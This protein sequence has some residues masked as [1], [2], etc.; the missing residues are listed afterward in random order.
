M[1]L[2]LYLVFFNMLWVF[3]PL[4]ALWYSWGDMVN[5]FMIRNG[6]VAAR[7]EMERERVRQDVEE[8]R[9]EK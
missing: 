3:L 7:L 6:V 8:Q 5:A 4:Y 9:K 1:F 2:W